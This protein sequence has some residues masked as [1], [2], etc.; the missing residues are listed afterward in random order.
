MNQINKVMA[1]RIQ[2]RRDT[3]ERWAQY[4]PVLLEGEV[5]YVTD[6]PNQYKIGDGIHAWNDLPLRGYTGTIVQETGN[7]E[8]S[9]MSQKSVTNEINKITQTVDSNKA[10]NGLSPSILYGKAYSDDDGTLENYELLDCTTLIEVPYNVSK[11]GINAAFYSIACFDYNKEFI[12]SSKNNEALPEGTR[13]FSV[14]FLKE[15]T[16]DYSKLIITIIQPYILEEMNRNNALHLGQG[17]ISPLGSISFSK[18]SENNIDITFSSKPN[19]FTN[20]GKRVNINI[21]VPKT[22]TLEPYYSLILDAETGELKVDTLANK[23]E[24]QPV[25]LAYNDSDKIASGILAPY[26]NYLQINS[27]FNFEQLNSGVVLPTDNI[28][29]ISNQDKSIDVNVLKSTWIFKNQGKYISIPVTEEHLHIENQYSLFFDIK[30]F[31]YIIDSQQNKHTD[32]ILLGLNNN[33]FFEYGLFSNLSF[34]DS[35]DN[36]DLINTSIN[37]IIG[38]SISKSILY[39][40]AYSD[41]SGNLSEF[42]LLD[43]TP[44]LEVPNNS[45]YVNISQ[46]PL[47]SIACFDKDKTYLGNRNDLPGNSLRIGWLFEG[48][49]YISIS[50]L[51][52]ENIDYSKLRVTFSSTDDYK[53]CSKIGINPGIMYDKAYKT[54]TGVLTTFTTLDC[55][56]PIQVPNSLSEITKIKINKEFYEIACFDKDRAFLGAVHTPLTTLKTG[57]KYF[58]VSFLTENNIDY[59]SLLIALD[60]NTDNTGNNSLIIPVSKAGKKY[61][62]F[63]DSI[64]YWDSRT[65]WYDPEVYMVAY[66]SYIR[67]VLGAEIVNKGVAG[68]TSNAITTR[69]LST[70]LS[71]AYAVTYMAGANDLHASVPI[72]EIGNLDRSTYIGNLSTAAEYVLTNYPNVKMYFLSPLWETNG[73]KGGY[74][75]YAEAM[76][77]VA[78]HYHIPIL[79]WDIKS[80]IGKLTADTFYVHEDTTRLHPNNDGHR[81]LSDSLIPFLQMY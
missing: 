32:A 4:N 22:Y 20:E 19:V 52:S 66:P 18:S 59:S 76:Q 6:N 77:S 54:D 49:K 44:L 25:I 69:L 36:I 71:D 67:D 51:K 13:F 24:G 73:D 5:G 39:G 79:R 11:I 64:T 34:K 8:N 45:L 43:C 12:S 58:S 46:G 38:N 3:A 29:I 47:F 63:G 23:Q 31:E 40:K 14:S 42:N 27:N 57:T 33:G 53:I 37:S 15:N 61:Y 62:L 21:E 17:Q 65:S 81:R 28:Q 26:Y 55:T 74:E 1:D 16:I 50:F 78:E 9:V 48:T 2:Q 60:S 68:N 80:G 7:D 75:D 35:I 30:S 70:D 56:P 72:G 41:A 10:I